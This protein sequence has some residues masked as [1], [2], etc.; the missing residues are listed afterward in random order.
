MFI[1]STVLPIE[2]VYAGDCRL[3]LP[4]FQRAYAWSETHVGR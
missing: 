2:K 3:E 4:W 1:K